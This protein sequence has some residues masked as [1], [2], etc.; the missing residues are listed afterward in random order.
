MSETLLLTAQKALKIDDDIKLLKAVGAVATH[1]TQLAAEV[2]D[3]ATA[4][5]LLNAIA[6]DVNGDVIGAAFAKL[7]LDGELDDLRRLLGRV[8]GAANKVPEEVRRLL[9]RLDSFPIGDAKA[10]VAWGL[11]TSTDPVVKTD[12]YSLDLGG[13]IGVSLNAGGAWPGDSPPTRRL[14][15]SAHGGARAGATATAPYAFGSIQG[16]AGGSATLALDYY[17]AA[18]P[19]ELYALAVARRLGDLANP[20]DLDSVWNAVQGSDLDGLTY[21]FG[22]AA[23]ANLKVTF[24]DAAVLA[25]G[26][27]VDASFTID[28]SA[29]LKSDYTLTLRRDAQGVAAKLSRGKVGETTF[30]DALTVTVDVSTLTQPVAKAITR[31]VDKWDHALETIKPY[32]SPGSWL[33][34]QAASLLTQK[35]TAL[36]ADP[37]VRAAAISDMKGA[38]GLSTVDDPAI[39]AWLAGKVTGAIDQASVLV[40]GQAG[41]AVDRAAAK[42]TEAVPLLAGQLPT[43][44]LKALAK[45]LI[46]KVETELKAKVQALFGAQGA[47]LKT[48]LQKAGAEIGGA[49]ASLDDA[50]K[51][52]RD[53]LARYDAVFHK[54]LDAAQA[55]AKAKVTARLYRTETR[56]RG[57]VVEVAG[58]F[59]GLDD[60]T[61]KVFAALTRGSLAHLERLVDGQ[62]AAPHF[63]LDRAASS[64]KRFSRFKSEEGIEIVFL[65]VSFK[66]VTKVEI[67][68]EVLIDGLGDVHVDSHANLEKRLSLFNS[69]E[70][71]F[72]DAYRLV[73]AAAEREAGVVSPSFEVGF[74]AAF[75]DKKLNWKDVSAFV[76]ELDDARLLA[77]G[78]IDGLRAAFDRWS[79]G[80]GAIKGEIAASLRLK[81]D[82]LETLLRRKLNDGK[83]GL[84]PAEQADILRVAIATAKR[85]KAID[86][87]DFDSGLG[88]AFNHFKPPPLP[89]PVYQQDVVLNYW[90]KIQNLA[91]A[92]KDGLPRDYPL[93]IVSMSVDD[94]NDYAYFVANGY[95]LRR[96]V[97]LIE[98]MGQ[99]YT[100][101]PSV[102]G[103]PGWSEQQFLEHQET[104]VRDSETWLHVFKDIRSLWSS[105]ITPRTATLLRVLTDL[106]GRTADTPGGLT[107]TL[108][109][110]P[111]G[112]PAQTTSFG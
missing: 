71:S 81:G 50:L 107:L 49:V 100:A 58:V 26:I 63:T 31:A 23:N 97:E 110:R 36:I 73:Q 67:D 6:A 29:S 102:G 75:S 17:F 95:A 94:Q 111:N 52:V 20:F 42:L 12:R 87:D 84:T 38:L 25:R 106:S 9:S 96:I 82:A 40:E 76:K 34:D 98:T 51:G 60:P 83:A 18:K 90:P 19:D 2:D 79:P 92:T 103:G 109:W 43:D 78:A 55:A 64:V 91:A 39:V 61:R 46:D 68:A 101:S 28:V 8:T 30:S 21:T 27:K 45:D 99:I 72:V 62:E 80:G 32:L 93:P 11:A 1:W 74:G 37:A 70:V 88:I 85:R 35:L 66:A 33:R 104:L 16:G 41:S 5:A 14:V 44:K 13:D 86:A 59:T 48:L 77:P 22:G 4:E 54:I 57:D 47:A 65:G 24:A 108:T 105:K 69:R 112:A 3:Y 53:L 56:T 89:P 10:K 7:N 15:I